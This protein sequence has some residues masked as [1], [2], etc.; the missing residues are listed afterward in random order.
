MGE[1]RVGKVMWITCRTA[2]FL[3]GGRHLFRERNTKYS[4][5]L[6]KWNITD[7]TFVILPGPDILSLNCRLKFFF[8]FIL[9]SHLFYIYPTC[10]LKLLYVFYVY[11][12]L[13]CDCWICLGYQNTCKICFY[14]FTSFLTLIISVFYTFN[15]SFL[16]SFKNPIVDIRYHRLEVLFFLICLC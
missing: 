10:T 7:L 6:Q 15:A 5:I 9:Q 14:N 3:L 12:T 8:S 1:R 11:H 13:F 4:K 16:Y 2:S